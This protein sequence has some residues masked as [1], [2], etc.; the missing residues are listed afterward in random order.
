MDTQ[1]W[2][3]RSRQKIQVSTA[4]Y[5]EILAAKTIRAQILQMIFL[6]ELSFLM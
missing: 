4:V 3:K 6:G 2:Q 1:I 5:K